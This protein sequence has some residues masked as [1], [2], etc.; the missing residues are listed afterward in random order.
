MRPPQN[1]FVMRLLRM[2]SDLARSRNHG[3]GPLPVAA[4][5][6]IRKLITTTIGTIFNDI[7]PMGGRTIRTALELLL[8][9]LLSCWARGKINSA[10]LIDGE[11]IHHNVCRTG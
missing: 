6:K 2:S 8:L 10:I 3:H 4:G 9:L 7:S 11:K 5:E 1:T